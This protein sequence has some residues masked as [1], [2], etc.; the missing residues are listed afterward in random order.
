M[1][2]ER[3]RRYPEQDEDEARARHEREERDIERAD[4]LMDEMRDR[5]AEQR[6]EGM[7]DDE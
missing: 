2:L 3:E 7:E 5:R 4:Y 1:K 6:D